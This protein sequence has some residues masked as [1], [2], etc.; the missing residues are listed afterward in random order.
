MTAPTTRLPQNHVIITSSQMKI[1]F[2]QQPNN[3]PIVKDIL[4]NGKQ[5][6]NLLIPKIKSTLVGTKQ[7]R[8]YSDMI[9]FDPNFEKFAIDYFDELHIL[10]QSNLDLS[11][12]CADKFFEIVCS[13]Y[14]DLI[15]KKG[16]KN[17]A[18]TFL[19]KIVHLVEKWENPRQHK[20]IHKGTPYYFLTFVYREM[21]DIE[22]AFATAFKA[23]REDKK[24]YSIFGSG[25]YKKAPAYKYVTILDDVNNYLYET[26]TELRDMLGEYITQYQGQINPN[27][28]IADVDS[29]F[30]Q[31]GG[32]LENLAFV[33]VYTLELIKKYQNQIPSLPKNDFYKIKNLHNIFN[34]CLI[35]DKILQ[36]KYKRR[37][38]RRKNRPNQKMYIS[39]GIFLLFEDKNWINL[40][41]NE[42]RQ[43]G[44]LIG[45][46]NHRLP[47]APKALTEQLILNP[48]ANQF[49]LQNGTFT[50]T[51]EMRN[52][53]F[54]YKLRNLG[55]HS[56]ESHTIL[57]S[58]YNE[59]IKHL[60]FAIFSSINAL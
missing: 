48:Q 51:N 45:S 24:S 4:F 46:I 44:A 26:V 40:T 7:Y 8:P 37:F 28:T 57:V 3:F 6:H 13:I 12:V 10:S 39:D 30:L 19:E 9:N 20:R 34:L 36:H 41:A 47:N 49:N 60:M 18:C 33:F 27:F 54:A 1:L 23:I 17:Q 31:N 38:G 43:M 29:K 32:Q 15:S 14:W 53:L 56:L 42:K 2:L 16:S 25:Q 5:L 11:I 59:I 50:V 35:V 55:A 52:L 22:S 58:K 21:G